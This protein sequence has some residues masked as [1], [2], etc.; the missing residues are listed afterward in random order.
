M[1]CALDG[2]EGSCAP[3]PS[4]QNPSD[5]CPLATSCDGKGSC[6]GALLWARR[7]GSSGDGAHGIATDDSGNILLTGVFRDVIEFGASTLTSAG[8]GDV[9][10]LKLSPL[11]KVL[12][13]KRFGGVNSDF[14]EDLAVDSAGH[15]IIVGRFNDVVDF[16]AGEHTSQGST[17]IFALEL[18]ED[19]NTVWSK[20]FGGPAKDMGLSVAI[21]SVDDVVLVGGFNDA[22]DFGSGPVQSAGQSDIFVL[23]LDGKSGTPQWSQQYGGAGPDNAEAVVIDAADK[24]IV[25]A[26]FKQTVDFGDGPQVSAGEY[27]MAVVKLDSAGGFLWQHSYGSASAEELRGV[28]VNSAGFIMAAGY[29]TASLSF[30][31]EPVGNQGG[32]DIVLFAVG[33]DASHKVS[34][35]FGDVGSDSA[36]GIAVDAT[37]QVIAVGGFMGSVDFGGGALPSHGDKDAFVVKLAPNGKHVWSR[38][39]GGEGND[40]ALGVATTSESDV[41]VSGVFKE[42]MSLGGES[43]VSA[44]DTDLFVVKLAP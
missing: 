40:F 37:G 3:I 8:N 24:V 31:G 27:D 14:G 38:S 20:S 10:V 42:T 22:V 7:F 26:N 33:P 18:D 17:D 28:A 15:I 21:S 29:S 32:A 11:G 12:W 19:G 9:F 16:G 43:F 6:Q 2:S 34:R 4:G 35:S 5:D 39:F 13:A 1:S 44:G 23:A 41:L 36:Y 25:T 30:G